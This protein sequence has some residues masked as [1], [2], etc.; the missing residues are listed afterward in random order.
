[1][2]GCR[3]RQKFSCYYKNFALLDTWLRIICELSLFDIFSPIKISCYADIITFG[4]I[5]MKLEEE[6]L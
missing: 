3:L 1:M 2:C 4:A 6:C 5:A